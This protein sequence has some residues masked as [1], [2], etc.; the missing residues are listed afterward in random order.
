MHLR[1]TLQQLLLFVNFLDQSIGN[2]LQVDVIYLD[3]KK[4]FDSVAHNELLYKL[5]NIGLTGSVW[6]WLQAYLTNRTQ[7]VSINSAI[8]TPLPV[9]S[10]VPQGSILGPL[11]FLLFINDLPDLIMSRVL[12]FA[13]DAKCYRSITSITDCLKLQ[14]DLNSLSLWSSTWSLHFNPQKCSVLSFHP[15]HSEAKFNHPYYMDSTIVQIKSTP[16]DLGVVMSENLQWSEHYQS[17]LAKAYKLLGLIRRVFASTY[18]PLAKKVLYISLIRSKI[19][20]CSPVWHPYL[21]VDIRTLE[22][23]Q[24]RATKF[25]L[26]DFHSSYR[27]RLT[28][29]HLLPLMLI[30]EINDILFFLKQLKSPSEHFNISTLVSFC[31]GQTRS[32]THFKM[33]IPSTTTN[34]SRNMYFNCLPRLWNALPL[35]NTNKSMITIKK[36]LYQLFRKHFLEKFDPDFPFT[37]HYICPCTKCRSLPV[38]NN[39]DTSFL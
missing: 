19:T 6:N 3:F 26:N 25:V 28:E 27:H 39:Y 21:L 5:W 23:I 30:F 8:S 7:C 1:S 4:A 14:E 37:F 38:S 24:R 18:C 13:D 34:S 15:S 9:K 29:L 20:Y 12:L 36:D 11:L 10:G 35:I 33:K 2:S 22:S 17:M 32:A 16:R 31:S